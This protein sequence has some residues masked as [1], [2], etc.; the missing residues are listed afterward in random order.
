MVQH[1]EYIHMDPGMKDED[2]ATAHTV[3][4]DPG[5]KDEDTWYNKTEHC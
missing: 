1:T 2:P 3:H 5:M 4:M